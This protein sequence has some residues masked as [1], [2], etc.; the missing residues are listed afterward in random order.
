MVRDS[1]AA[2]RVSRK[3]M[4]GGTVQGSLMQ[5]WVG[6]LSVKPV[7]LDVLNH[8]CPVR[9]FFRAERIVP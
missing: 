7:V 1:L 5:E 3:A 4:L 8:D 2:T 6:A 9:W